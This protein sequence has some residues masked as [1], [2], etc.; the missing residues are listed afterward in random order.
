[1]SVV[2]DSPRLRIRQLTLADAPF[3]QRLVTQASWLKYIGDRNVHNQQDAERYI[4]DGPLAMYTKHG[5]G[6]WIVERK[7]DSTALGMAGLLKRDT[8]ADI[9][10]GYALLDEY[11]GQG[12]ATEAVGA[13]LIYARDIVGLRR[14]VAITTPDNDRSM[15]LLL[16]SGFTREGTV[17]QHGEVLNLFAIN[18]V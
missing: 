15:Q 17:E 14:I 3:I 6:L 2:T 8:L 10:I 12:Y 7:S 18:Y 9:D 1:M 16:R 13:V 5:F 11:L 4:T